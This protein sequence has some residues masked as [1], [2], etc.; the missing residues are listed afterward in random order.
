MKFHCFSGFLCL[1]LLISVQGWWETGHMLVAQIAKNELLAEHPDIYERAENITLLLKGLTQNLTDT[2]VE[3][4]VWL[5]DIKEDQWESFYSWHFVDRPVNPLGM[6]VVPESAINAV[7]AIEEASKVLTNEKR[8]GTITIAKSVFMRVLLHVVGDIHQP[9]H[10]ADLYNLTFPEGDEGGNKLNVTVKTH[11]NETMPLHHYWDAIAYRLPD[12]LK[13]PLNES[14]KETLEAWAK[15]LT[16]EFPKDFFKEELKI[17]DITQWTID[18]YLTAVEHAYKPLRTDFIIDKVYEE[19]AFYI[20]R[21]NLALAGYRL[22][23]LIPTILQEEVLFMKGTGRDSPINKPMNDQ[24]L[25]M[26]I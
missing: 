25:Q 11:N 20:M 6:P 4:A 21:R 26:Y 23:Q 9:L 22:A 2:F 3:A 12:D 1:L 19:Q 15:K 5:D 18:S 14:A 8:R 24:F 10:C 7:Y 17:K 13:R 16:D